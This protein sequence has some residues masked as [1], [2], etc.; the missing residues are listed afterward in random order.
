MKKERVLIE[1]RRKMALEST[2][3]SIFCLPRI[4]VFDK[5][6]G[7][8]F[9]TRKYCIQWLLE[10]H[11]DHF[12]TLIAHSVR[13]AEIN[14]LSTNKYRFQIVEDLDEY[15]NSRKKSGQQPIGIL[16]G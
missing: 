8:E 6:N 11:H 10:S 3:Q 12:M 2:P 5:S 9:G 15:N 16:N 13:G 1:R 4:R 7:T 14:S